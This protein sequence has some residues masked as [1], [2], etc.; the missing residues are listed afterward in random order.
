M[1][2]RTFGLLSLL[3]AGCGLSAP[4][5]VED[6]SPPPDASPAADAQPSQEPTAEERATFELFLADVKSELTASHTPGAS[7]AI[8][9]HGKLAFA[10]GV[11]TKGG[12]SQ[13]SVTTST[14]FRAASLSKMVLAATAMTLVDEG[15]LD[16]H[17]PITKYLPWFVLW[18]GFDAS[19]ITMHHLLSHTS[20]FP[21]DTLAICGGGLLS[22]PSKTFA[23][24]VPQPLWAKPGDVWNYSNMGYAIASLVVASAAGLPEDDFAKAVQARIFDRA[25]MTNATYDAKVAEAAD[26]ATGNQ[27]NDTY[28]TTSMWKPASFDCPLWSAPAGI[29]ATATD[30][31]HFAELLIAKGGDVVRSSSVDLMRA[32][33]ASVPWVDTQAYGYGLMSYDYPYGAAHPFVFHTGSQRGF[34][35]E[36]MMVPSMGFAVVV[37]ANARGPRDVPGKLGATAIK[38]F[39]SETQVWPGKPSAPTLEEHVG[40]YV[41]LAG[42]LGTVTLKIEAPD[43]GPKVLVASAPEATDALGNARPIQGTMTQGYGDGWVFPGGVVATFYRDGAGRVNRIVTREGIAT[44]TP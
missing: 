35:S 7:V 33:Q 37:L 31:A 18:N 43:G 12:T 24:S 16:L 6:S 29:S 14:R 41:D 17:A 3:L 19:S 22:G 32:P 8:V 1:H 25:S 26:F 10:A 9:L 2:T 21:C 11:G 40:V 23:Q 13:E 15:K 42:N 36:L 5:S 27:L 20:G 28:A 30:F 38:R 4:T 44:R 34:L 39:I